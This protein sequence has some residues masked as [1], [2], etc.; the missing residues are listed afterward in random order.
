MQ[1]LAGLLA[2]VCRVAP[3]RLRLFQGGNARTLGPLLR[4]ERA[5]LAA[6]CDVL[7]E[8]HGECQHNGANGDRKDRGA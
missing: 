7:L 2:D 4:G 5:H 3:P 1:P 8:R 6:L